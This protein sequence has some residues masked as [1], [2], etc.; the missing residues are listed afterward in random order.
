MPIGRKK[1]TN[2]HGGIKIFLY[3]CDVIHLEDWNL[4]NAGAVI[5]RMLSGFL[6]ARTPLRSDFSRK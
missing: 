3:I 1:Q 4:E 6:V 5:F 2:V